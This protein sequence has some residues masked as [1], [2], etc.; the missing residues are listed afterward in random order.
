MTN[1]EI[2]KRTFAA[3]NEDKVT[4]L[5]AAIAF[6]TIFSLAPLFIVLIAIVGGIL[7]VTGAHG[8]TRAENLL[9][10][11]V[12][13][14]AGPG[15]ADSVRGLIA[16][17]FNKPRQGV[18][19]QI[20]GWI[21]F[22]FAASGLF[23]ALQDALNTVW[24]IEGTKGGIKFMVR[25]RAASAAMVVVVGFLVLVTFAANAA[26]AFV[27]THFLAAIP[28]GANPV[29]VS[30]IGEVLN[31][32]LIAAIFAML[33]KIL[34]DVH[35]SWSDVRL[36]AIFTAVLFL[37]GEALIAIYFAR[38]GVAS[39]YGAAGSLLVALL[40]IY[41]SAVILLLGAEFTKIV[42][43]APALSVESVVRRTSD[44][45]AGADPRDA[46]LARDA[47]PVRDG[48]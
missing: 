47:L 12:S 16:A 24:Q 20:V 14:S 36:G 39:A 40:W 30:V 34:P 1:V 2:A 19:A 43:H 29:V 48:E 8:H 11:A 22:V 23:S 6:S 4:R 28:F 15:T 26:I 33:F 13:K 9:L 42:A 27:T 17:S 7:G 25:A 38:A 44:L 41:Y 32:A 10:S 3:F 37:V 31:F 46:A 18:I 45:P 35:L 5:A 21:A